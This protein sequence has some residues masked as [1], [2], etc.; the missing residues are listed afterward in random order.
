MAECPILKTPP[1]E[2]RSQGFTASYGYL[3]RLLSGSVE[4]KRTKLMLVGLGEAG[5]T[6]WVSWNSYHKCIQY[7]MPDFLFKLVMIWYMHVKKALDVDLEYFRSFGIFCWSSNQI[8]IAVGYI[9]WM[10]HYCSIIVSWSLARALQSDDL[11]SSLT[12]HESIT[13]GRY[14]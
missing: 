10:L 11:K 13:D 1:K 6:R 2:I 12:G 8:Y 9:L 14:Q 4:C 5:K 3:R 7:Q